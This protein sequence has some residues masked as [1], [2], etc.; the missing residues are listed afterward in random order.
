MSKK[1]FVLKDRF[2]FQRCNQQFYPGFNIL[3]VKNFYGRVN[4]P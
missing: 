1:R 4:I 2:M 3:D